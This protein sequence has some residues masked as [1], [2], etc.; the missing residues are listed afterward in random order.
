MTNCTANH[1]TSI[2]KCLLLI[3]Q[4]TPFHPQWFAL[5]K[6]T[7]QLKKICEN[8]NG[9]ICDVGC[10]DAK[11]KKYLPD[12]SRYIGID[13]YKTATNWY[14]TKPTLFADAQ[15]LP[16]KDNSIDHFLMLDVLEHLPDP[17]KSLGDILRTLKPG[18]TLTILVPFLYPIHDAPLDFRRWTHFG[19]RKAADINGFSLVEEEAIGH[20]LETAALNANIAVSKTVLNWIK[21]NNLLGTL[22]L[23][24]PTQVLLI[25]VLAWIFAK[26]SKPDD[27]MPNSY[28]MVW[29]K[30]Q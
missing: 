19:L 26:L 30:L 18:G 16:I 11:P 23:L 1:L 7:S 3:L 10:A 20:P 15:S 13:H 22:I 24:L 28:R 12:N 29:K 9:I 8:L 5:Y 2:K 14:K 21:N 27:F 25:N 4:L 6:H 17:D